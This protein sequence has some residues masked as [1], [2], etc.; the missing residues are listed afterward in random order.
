VLHPDR[1]GQAAQ[2]P[3]PLS[4]PPGG[5]QL[6]ETTFGAAPL[7]WL[8]EAPGGDPARGLD[9]AHG[10]VEAWAGGTVT[11]W[12]LEGRTA[13]GISLVDAGDEGAL[14][15]SMTSWHAHAFE[16]HRRDDAEA[17]R[18]F[19]GEDEAAVLR[20]GTDEVRYALAPDLPSALV[21]VAPHA[22]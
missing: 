2:T 8:F 13:V 11:A 14:C 18:V 9:D 7:L 6:L 4:A 15:D 1:A 22:P 5:E 17:A 10:R 20:C 16:D 3:T 21:M 12:D 19:R